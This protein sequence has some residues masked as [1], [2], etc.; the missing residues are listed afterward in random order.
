MLFNC[1]FHE[2]IP[3]VVI[4]VYNCAV[5]YVQHMQGRRKGGGGRRGGLAPLALSQGGQ[6]GQKCPFIKYTL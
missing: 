2:I 3:K 5:F 1:N 6:G 4:L